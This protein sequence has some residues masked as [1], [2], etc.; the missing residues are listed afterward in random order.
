[1]YSLSGERRKR[2][3]KL[4]ELVFFPS[5]CNICSTLLE[6]PGER[7]VCR[8]C[9]QKLR[10]E[11]SAFCLCCGRFFEGRIESHLCSACLDSPPA[12]SRHRS[13][14]RYRGMAKD[15]IRLFKYQKKKILGDD[16]ALFL[17]RHLRGEDPLWWGADALV[18]VPLH[19]HRLRQRGFN[20]AEILAR[21]LSRLSGIEL[22]TNRLIKVRDAQPQTT[23]S[24]ENRRSNLKG[25]YSVRHGRLLSGK[26][27]ILVDDVFTTGATM[28]ECSRVLKEAG[29]Q[30]VRAVTIAQA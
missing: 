23:L 18:P 26:T 24:G 8:G 6:K 10:P 20:Q 22:Q 21:R 27:V 1:L 17:Y 16:L 2:L 11:S 13:V 29:V 14:C 25:A 7:I 5:F 3:V 4:F 28:G 9:L 15:L 19:P 12:Y 30:E